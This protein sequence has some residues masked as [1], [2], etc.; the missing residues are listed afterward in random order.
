MRSI[1]L[2]FRL[3][4]QQGALS[5]ESDQARR[6]GLRQRQDCL[7]SEAALHSE[8]DAWEALVRSG[9]C[10]VGAELETRS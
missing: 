2:H 1:A 8:H 7:G 9:A 4:E 6:W 3:D 5:R 10:G